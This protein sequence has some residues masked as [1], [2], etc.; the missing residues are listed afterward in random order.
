MI[1]FTQII[2]A[3]VGG[4]LS[5][6]GTV[7]LAW[8]QKHMKD[9]TAAATIGTA[10]NNALGAVQQAVDAGIKSHP[11]QAQI[12][13]ITPAAAA[14]VQYVLDNAGS[15][16]ARFTDITPATIAS[17]I[18]AKIGLTKS[19]AVAVVAASPVAA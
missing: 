17:K 6:V 12:P 11:L 7:F 10:V 16:L 19:A 14:G 1:D 9:Q 5:I 15:E 8:L 13:G 18:D 2:I 3:I 4:I